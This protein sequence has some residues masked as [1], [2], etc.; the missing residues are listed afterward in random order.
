MKKHPVRE[1]MDIHELSQPEF[2][3]LVGVSQPS[4]WAWLHGGRV[5]VDSAYSIEEATGGEIK[6][7]EL[8][9]WDRS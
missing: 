6:A 9:A 1:Y 8:F 5:S 7:T 3:N 2:A 4:V